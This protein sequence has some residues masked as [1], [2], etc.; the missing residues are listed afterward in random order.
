MHNIPRS[1]DKISQNFF[2]ESIPYEPVNP[3]RKQSKEFRN[4][5]DIEN[6]L[7]RFQLYQETDFACKYRN[8]LYKTQYSE[9]LVEYEKGFEM[10]TGKKN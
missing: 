1:N 3:S 5:R 2:I 9:I 4:I 8:P 10:T 7:T 6:K